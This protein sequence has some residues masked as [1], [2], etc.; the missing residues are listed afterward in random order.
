MRDGKEGYV[1]GL[2]GRRRRAGTTV[3]KCTRRG[4]E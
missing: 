2:K 3:A 4:V 1:R